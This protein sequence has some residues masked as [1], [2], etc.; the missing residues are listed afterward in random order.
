MGKIEFIRFLDKMNQNELQDYLEEVWRG[1]V[2]LTDW[3]YEVL[4]D[5]LRQLKA[6]DIAVY[7]M[8]YLVLLSLVEIDGEKVTPIT[9]I[10]NG[11][12]EPEL[13]QE[14][15]LVWRTK[16]DGKVCPICSPLDGKIYGVDFT[17]KPKLHPNCRCELEKVPR[18]RRAMNKIRTFEAG[19]VRAIEENGAKRLEVLAAPFGSPAKRDRYKQWFD[20]NTDF[21]IEIGDRRP[22]LYLHGKSPRGRS[23]D[24]P[25]TIGF[26][27]VSKLDEYGWWMI[28]DLDGSELAERSYQSALEGKCVA[29]TGSVDYLV[30]PPAGP[31]G[32]WPPGP[33]RCWP[34]AELSIFDI[35]ENRVPVSDDAI[36]LP[37]RALF[38]EHS[39]T[40]PDNFEAGE[41]KKDEE[42]NQS[43]RSIGENDMTTEIEKAVAEALAKRDALKQAEE[44][45]RA[46]MRAEIKAEM[47][48]EEPK[49]YRATFNIGGKVTGKN[50]PF[51][52]RATPEERQLYDKAEIEET[53]AFLYALMRP[54]QAPAAMR[55]L[56]ETEAAEGA[57]LIPTPMLNRI[58]A[59][60]DEVSLVNAIG[61]QKMY[62]NSLTLKVPREDAAM[63]VFATIAEEGNYVANEPA[64]SAETVTVVKKG[65]MVTVT[66]EMLEDSSI[67]EP[68]FVG[69]CG[70]KWGLTENLIL[71]TELKADDT[72]GTHSATF[73]QAEIDAYMYQIE[74]PWA[75]GAHLIMAQ[76][77]MGT[78]RGLLVATPRAYG[79]FPNFG[80]LKYPTLF[81]YP[82]H[83]DSNWEAVGAGDTTLT[84]SLVNPAAISWVERRGL[85]IKVD[86]YGDA[87]A[88]RVRYFP[89]FRAACA[90]TQVKGNVSYTDHA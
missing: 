78:I 56:E 62:T 33:V 75:D 71:F 67:F 85:S 31:D 41:D 73:T 54:L 16:N 44:E 18:V 4:L 48:A 7:T 6:Q 3:Q 12:P 86:P 74:D 89:S 14:Y 60:R 51:A 81:G 1:N 17:I 84:M 88:G 61:I 43:N 11:M 36:V 50:S 55:V 30:R 19:A 37:L 76:A 72:A 63:A 25:T 82:T 53:D 79:D 23:M 13:P 27:T 21:M 77:T 47:E 58:V 20:I 52:F 5:Q 34:I 29:S 26:A 59:L 83:L 64:F 28:S 69:L 9:P 15:D 90:T 80:D 10:F 24:Q 38:D 57:G 66:E 39:I 68:Y 70:R 22:L 42:D 46:A 2:E 87:L 49:N 35:G 65:S 8:V 32:N 40:L 45:A